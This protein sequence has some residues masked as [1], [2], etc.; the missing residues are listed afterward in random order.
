[1]RGGTEKVVMASVGRAASTAGG[2]RLSVP[3][4]QYLPTGQ[5][6]E[7]TPKAMLASLLTDPLP[8]PPMENE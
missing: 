3:G 7:P 6:G 5:Q 1:M 2:Q 8:T 4:S